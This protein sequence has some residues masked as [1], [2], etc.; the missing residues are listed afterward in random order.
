MGTRGS[1]GM[2]AATS[3]SA[4]GSPAPTP[5]RAPRAAEPHAVGIGHDVAAPDAAQADLVLLEEP[6]AAAG[7]QT[8]QVMLAEPGPQP[9][10]GGEVDAHEATPAVCTAA[11]IASAARTAAAS[12]GRSSTGR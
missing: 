10:V 1:A 7:N 4:S 3:P 12:S 8:R 11:R 6:R 5:G 9:L 2:R